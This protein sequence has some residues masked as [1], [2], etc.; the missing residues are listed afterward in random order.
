M[1]R[2][3]G[4]LL[5][6]ALLLS[7]ALGALPA[8]AEEAT[9]APA[10]P[11]GSSESFVTAENLTGIKDIKD[12]DGKDYV[13]ALKITDV[14]GFVRLS[15]IVNGT[16]EGC[17]ARSM[18]NQT[19]Y[20]AADLDLSEV[21]G[22]E[23]IGKLSSTPFKGT[24]DGQG[25]T[26]GGLHITTDG[27][28]NAALF[29][30][31]DGVTIRNLNIGTGCVFAGETGSVAGILGAV[32]GKS[33]ATVEN[34]LVQAS[35]TGNKWVGGVVGYTPVPVT[36]KNC[37]NAGHV[38]STDNAA[39]KAAGGIIGVGGGTIE[40][41]RN[42]G[43]VTAS[44]FVG[45]IVGRPAGGNTATITN[46]VNDG[47]LAGPCRGAATGQIRNAADRV[48]RFFN[49]SASVNKAAGHYLNGDEATNIIGYT[50]RG[51]EENAL[52]REVLGVRIQLTNGTTAASGQTSLRLVSTVD[53][54]RYR[55]VGFEI[56]VRQ[57][58]TVLA[59]KHREVVRTVYQRVG[60]SAE[61]RIISYE[62]YEEF[63][64]VSQY[65][66]TF[67][68]SDIPNAYFDA[69]IICTAYA[70]LPDGTE[71]LGDT[72]TVNLAQLLAG[73]TEAKKNR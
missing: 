31:G 14:D 53:S 28:N 48:N 61:D 23:P 56:T 24:F 5:S 65:F 35:V 9:P 73:N 25:R 4:L 33:G 57:G 40:N 20:L 17:A 51:S 3:F 26:I 71:V 32:Q 70:I 41:C 18:Y 36:V 12:Y 2:L 16:L 42:S 66:S 8:Y 7:L 62:A 68:I 22:F 49:Y 63:S 58:D 55:S 43:T 37:T 27:S 69:D 29:G 11:V 54:L 10:A 67:T 13:K 44:Y 30:C 21:T 45:G 52:M 72:V 46:C 19:V 6:A 15:E 50:D 47:M 38:T 34:C 60:A 39:D 64:P 59:E 1:K